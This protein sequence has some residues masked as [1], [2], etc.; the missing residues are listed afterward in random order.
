MYECRSHADRRYLYGKGWY[1]I[2]Y[3]AEPILGIELRPSL[4]YPLVEWRQININ[5]KP[6]RP[7]RVKFH[8]SLIYDQIAF[9]PIL[10]P[11][12]AYKVDRRVVFLC[13]EI[14]D[15]LIRPAKQVSGPMLIKR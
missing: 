5:E 8:L 15:Q 12:D 4:V 1:F 3:S 7:V 13:V 6:L 14:A 9:P 10:S 11:F 2:K